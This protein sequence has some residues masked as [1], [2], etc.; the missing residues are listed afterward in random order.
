M[1]MALHPQLE[2]GPYPETSWVRRRQS[3]MSASIKHSGMALGAAAALGTAI[4]M[5]NRRSA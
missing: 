1:Q 3:A 4:W 2:E 5:A